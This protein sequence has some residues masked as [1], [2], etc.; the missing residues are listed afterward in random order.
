MSNTGKCAA[1]LDPILDIPSTGLTSDWPYE[2]DIP[3][4]PMCA[5]L[6]G[7]LGKQKLECHHK[8]IS[9]HMF[10]LEPATKEKA[11]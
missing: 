6:L 9:T 10:G 11:C 3:D 2:G 4:C 5:T 7:R 8:T 1:P